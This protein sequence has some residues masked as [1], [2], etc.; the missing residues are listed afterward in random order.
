MCGTKLH[1]KNS[2]VK[3]LNVTGCSL[4]IRFKRPRCSLVTQIDSNPN[5]LNQLSQSSLEV[6]FK[7]HHLS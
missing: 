1:P 5:L 3:P 4:R 2:T 7:I 6:I